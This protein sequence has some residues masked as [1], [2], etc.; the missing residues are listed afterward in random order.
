MNKSILIGAALL[1]LAAAPAAMAQTVTGTVN[2]TGSVA[3]RCVVITGGSGGSFS[4]SIPLGELAGTDGTLSTT[5]A[6]STNAAPGGSTQFRVNCNSAAPKVT[7]SSTRLALSPTATAPTGYANVIDYTAALDASLA[8]GSTQTVSY[9][10]AAA[11]PAATVQALS[12][13]LANAANNLTVKAYALNTAS[14]AL[15]M[16]GNYSSVISITIEPV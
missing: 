13:S 2:V 8:S 9:V 3:A 12:D 11:L 16:A 1:G 14:G 15:L 10:T 5:L 6:G 4:G 7:L